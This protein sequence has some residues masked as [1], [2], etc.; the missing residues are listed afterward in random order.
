MKE[1]L[2]KMI[3]A[4][5]DGYSA[6]VESYEDEDGNIV[7]LIVVENPDSKYREVV[8]YVPEDTNYVLTVKDLLW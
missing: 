1:K 3:Q 4:I 7:Y 5:Q 8:N 2:K 6:N